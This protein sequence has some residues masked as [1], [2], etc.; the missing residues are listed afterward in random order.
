MMKV[1]RISLVVLQLVLGV[2]VLIEAGFLA[3]SPSQIHA[4][5]KL[6]LPEHIR[7]LLAWG[8]IV[9]AVLFLVPRTVVIGG[10]VLLAVFVAA[11]AVHLFHGHGSPG[12]LLIY[13]AAVFAVMTNRHG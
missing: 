8:E 13:A 11:A 2:T 9:G 6:G 1:N 12:M 3:L 5:G 7:V 4:F 10:V